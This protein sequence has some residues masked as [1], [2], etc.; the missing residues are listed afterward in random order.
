MKFAI[1]T[2]NSG[3]RGYNFEMEDQGMEPRGGG[4]LQKNFWLYT[5]YTM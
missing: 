4:N 3:P 2:F 5:Y 1:M